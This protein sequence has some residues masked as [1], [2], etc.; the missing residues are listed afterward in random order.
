M[1][2][3]RGGGGGAVGVTVRSQH[4]F[5][6]HVLK[7]AVAQGPQHPSDTPGNS[8][9]NLILVQA[10][11]QFPPHLILGGLVLLGE[12]EVPWAAGLCMLKI[13]R[14]IPGRSLLK[15]HQGLELAAKIGG[16]FH[17]TS[18]SGL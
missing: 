16:M 6:P 9:R 3:D 10:C 18:Y 4:Q 13:P 5:S 17:L 2:G 12:T 15:L 1:E 14:H 11:I 8:P 7:G